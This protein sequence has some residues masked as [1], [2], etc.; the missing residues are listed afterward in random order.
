M[1]PMI[2]AADFALALVERL[3]PILPAGFAARAE[4]GTVHID[5]AGGLGGATSVADLLEPDDLEAEDYAS[6]A[7]MVLS[8]AQDVVSE[9]TAEPWPVALGERLDLA[10]PGTR[11]EGRQIALYFGAEDQP[12]LTLPPI[13]L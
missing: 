6:A 10:E 9:T 4:G 12:L 2:T 3:T 13:P 5:A 8:M 1:I 11:V 7:W